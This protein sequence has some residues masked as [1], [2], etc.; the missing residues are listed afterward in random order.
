MKDTGAFLHLISEFI[1]TQFKDYRVW[2]IEI[3]FP[4]SSEETAAGFYKHGS[5]GVSASDKEGKWNYHSFEFNSPKKLD[6]EMFELFDDNSLLAF[7][8]NDSIVIWSE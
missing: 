6:K 2:D 7:V 5:L 8:K 1:L 3:T 4:Q